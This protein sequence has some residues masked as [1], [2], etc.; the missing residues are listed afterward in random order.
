MVEQNHTFKQQIEC[1]EREIS[2]RQRV[3]P[4]WVGNRKMKQEK[5]DYEIAC[6]RSVLYTLQ[7]LNR[8][9]EEATK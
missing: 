7:S 8:Q 3:Y 9:W 1:V 6:M 5:A 2:M 4:N